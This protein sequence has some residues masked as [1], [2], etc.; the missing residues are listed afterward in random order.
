M[1]FRVCTPCTCYF[2]KNSVHGIFPPLVGDYFFNIHVQ[3]H[4]FTCLKSW[5]NSVSKCPSYLSLSRNWVHGI[6]PR[7]K[8]ILYMHV[9]DQYIWI[10]PKLWLN[11]ISKC[12]SLVLGSFSELSPWDI[13]A[14]SWL[15]LGV[16]FCLTHSIDWTP[17][18][19]LNSI[20]AC[21]WAGGLYNY[22]NIMYVSCSVLISPRNM[23][24]R[25]KSGQL[26]ALCSTYFC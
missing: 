15:V 21:G 16:I 11:S 24:E 9:Y 18:S 22:H 25:K 7:L 10:V 4:I 2:S 12:I 26:F 1:L 19:W 13:P 20:S 5:L 14:V 23:H 8:N 17:K 6:F 3:C